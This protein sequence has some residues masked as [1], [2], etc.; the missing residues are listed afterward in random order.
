MR[1]YKWKLDTTNPA[2]L[3][4]EVGKPGQ[5]RVTICE[6]NNQNIWYVL[7]L[8]EQLLNVCKDRKLWHE[9]Q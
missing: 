6:K 3:I 5:Y 8:Q 2:L 7:I 1:A 4:K 9:Q